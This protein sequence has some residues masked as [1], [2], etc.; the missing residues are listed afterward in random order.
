M[1]IIVQQP[2][3]SN[4]NP[5]PMVYDSDTGRVIVDHNGYVINGASGVLDNVPSLL[6]FVNTPKTQTSGIQEAVDYAISMSIL[7]PLGSGSV[8]PIFPAIKIGVGFFVVNANINLQPL[9]NAAVNALTNIEGSGPYNTVIALANGIKGFVGIDYGVE[10]TMSDITFVS[11]S[12][13]DTPVSAIYFTGSSTSTTSVYK[14]IRCVFTNAYPGT[15]FSNSAVYMDSPLA[16]TILF[17]DCGFNLNGG[18]NVSITG[19]GTTP[20]TVN[21]KGST[22]VSGNFRF[23]NIH[24]VSFDSFTFTSGAFLLTNVDNF[25]VSNSTW[26]NGS[27]SS[28]GLLGNNGNLT[29]ENCYINT[30]I[31][32]ANG[33]ITSDNST[34]VLK[35]LSI[36]DS[37]IDLAGD[38]ALIPN[39]QLNQ[40][41]E[42]G[43]VIIPNGYTISIPGHITV[44]GTTGGNFVASMPEQAN[45]YKK[46]LIYLDAYENDTTTAQT[47]TY[48]VPFTTVVEIT[49][50]TPSVPGVSTSLTEFSIAPDTTT[51]Y[52]GIIVIEGY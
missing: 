29:I 6:G 38:T 2:K 28:G 5:Q 10:L 7:R 30:S 50:N 4:G 19:N 24:N 12:T 22:V 11:Q 45:S 40:Y 1:T 23:N 13:T 34:Y 48:P 3:D 31:P 8:L 49:S 33:I 25:K 15:S 44:A 47:Y 46:V 17:E 35:S 27:N 51:A 14:F 9:P 18:N 41:I 32:A 36:R 52:T 16:R 37:T 21:L 43:L 20:L 26:I 42:S 39:V